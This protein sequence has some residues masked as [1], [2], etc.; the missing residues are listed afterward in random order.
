MRRSWPILFSL[1]ALAA[2]AGGACTRGEAATNAA[3]A[4]LPAPAADGS[5]PRLVFFMNPNGRPCQIQDRIL[6]DLSAE[7]KNK[8]EVVSYRTT[9]R[10][11]G[12]RF[13]Q[14]GI[15]S[16]PALVLTDATG[17]EVRRA[18]PGIQGPAQVRQL[19]GR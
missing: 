14:Y 5:L 11:D 9:S 15:R 7:L 10:A 2:A 17:R 1:L 16:L 19:V 13:E 18:T 6:D 8:V 4:P 3:V 12:P